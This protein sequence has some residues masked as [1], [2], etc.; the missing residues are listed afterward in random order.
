M[1]KSLIAA[2]A[3]VLAGA[4]L[5][6]CAAPAMAQPRIGFGITVGLPAPVVYA[7]PMPVAYVEPAPVVYGGYGPVVRVGAPY[8]Y[9]DWHY[10]HGYHDYHGYYGYHGAY[11]GWHR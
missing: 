10:Y 1:K 5:L 11:H 3:G 4:A 6:V 7:A 2:T 9:H 8:Y